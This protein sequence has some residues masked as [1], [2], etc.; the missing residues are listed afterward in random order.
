MVQCFFYRSCIN[1]FYLR[2]NIMKF[3]SAAKGISKIFASEILTL[4]SVIAIGFA[5][6]FTI[7]FAANAEADA[8]LTVATAFTGIGTLLFAVAA[9]VL[10]VIALILM[11]IGV[12][13]AAKDEASFRVIIFL[14]IFSL[15]VAVAG[16]VF[17]GIFPNT[18]LP[19]NIA[20][21]VSNIISFICSILVILGIGNLAA[22]L[23][24]D[25]VMAK[26][27][28]LLKIIICIGVLSIIARI[29]SL[30]IP[31]T[32]TAIIVIGIAVLAMILCVVQY[33]LYLSLLA[34]AKTML[35]ES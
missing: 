14:T 32:V 35:N 11:I 12:I 31:S 33:I 10:M 25:K 6:I 28:S 16:A 19:Y 13:Q 15:I 24:N 5:G 1:Y 8:D 17:A 26:C 22:Q 18:K 21:V 20:T 3:P 30:F 4:I 2:R 34:N 29:V 23:K 9:C 27:G 7:V